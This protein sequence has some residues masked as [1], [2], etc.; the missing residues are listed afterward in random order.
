MPVLLLQQGM[1][2]QINVCTFSIVTVTNL[3]G[4]R[5]LKLKISNKSQIRITTP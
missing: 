1:V 5:F 2:A 4:Q 3:K